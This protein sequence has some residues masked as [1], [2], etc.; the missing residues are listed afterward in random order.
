[1]K[2][3]LKTLLEPQSLSLPIETHIETTFKLSSHISRPELEPYLGQT[4]K[5]MGTLQRFGHYQSA[6]TVCMSPVNMAFGDTT[7]SLKDSST[8]TIHHAWMIL[9]DADYDRF[10][11]GNQIAGLA[12]VILYSRT[13]GTM[14]YGFRLIPQKSYFKLLAICL[15]KII[16]SIDEECPLDRNPTP[17]IV[18]EFNEFRR[19]IRANRTIVQY[20]GLGLNECDRISKKIEKDLLFIAR[21]DSQLE[22]IRAAT[23]GIEQSS[24][25]TANAIA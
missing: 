24:T 4:V 10:S 8:I 23:R 21:H 13:N 25:V 1:M 16:T 6:K 15:A 14:S 3:E 12:E 11:A 9:D 20:H 18:K 2:N 19:Y 7:K 17:F 22:V 5:L